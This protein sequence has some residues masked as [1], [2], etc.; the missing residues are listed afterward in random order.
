MEAMET[1]KEL[2]RIVKLDEKVVNR[3]AAGEIIQRPVSALKEMLENSLDAGDAS[4]LKGTVIWII[5]LLSLILDMHETL[6]F[7]MWSLDLH[8]TFL[9]DSHL[10][11]NAG[12]YLRRFNA[13]KCGSQGRRKQATTD[14][15][16]WS[17]HPG[18]PCVFTLFCIPCA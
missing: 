5:I 7:M 10:F 3:I 8:L 9:E 13:D 11:Y 15:G 4:P 1:S 12:I 6:W 18:R 2:P 14:T 16:Q 17:W